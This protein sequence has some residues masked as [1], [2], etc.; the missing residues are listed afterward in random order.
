MARITIQG[1][2]LIM[3]M[4]MMK[5]VLMIMMKIIMKNMLMIMRM[6]MITIQ[7]TGEFINTRFFC[8]V[9]ALMHNTQVGHHHHHHDQIVHFERV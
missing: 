7:G 1:T 2:G 5:I 3:M 8:R 4:I 9:C 6:M